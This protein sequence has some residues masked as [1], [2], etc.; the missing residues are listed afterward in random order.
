MPWR[1]RRR[2][3]F[4]SAAS[5][6]RI[7]QQTSTTPPARR[8]VVSTRTSAKKRRVSAAK[9]RGTR[10][11]KKI[12]RPHEKTVCAHK[13]AIDPLRNKRLS[14]P[15]R[16]GALFHRRRRGKGVMRKQI[17]RCR[18][19]G[20]AGKN[21][22]AKSSRRSAKMPLTAGT[23]RS[24][25]SKSRAVR[26]APRRQPHGP[27]RNQQSGRPGAPGVG[28]K[29]ARWLWCA[30]GKCRPVTRPLTPPENQAQ[31]AIRSLCRNR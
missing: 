9:T 17:R 5:R 1:M 13:R 19:P 30:K 31:K 25:F 11:T 3:P 27:S 10:V 26:G 16:R 14:S 24:G 15:L 29:S 23:T 12:S 21:A 20:D 7:R 18:G 6:T 28:K 2:C 22:K 8:D 4:A